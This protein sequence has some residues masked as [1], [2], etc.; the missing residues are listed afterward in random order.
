[1]EVFMFY[2]VLFLFI[3]LLAGVIAFSGIGGSAANTA[4]ILAVVAL[5]L[6]VVYAVRGRPPV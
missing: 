3:A 5:V 4:W 2:S 6:S 1:M